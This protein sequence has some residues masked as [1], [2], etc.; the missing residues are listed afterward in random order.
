MLDYNLNSLVGPRCTELKVETPDKYR[1]QPRTLLQ[2]L[3]TVYL[4]LCKSKEFIQAVARDGRSYKKELFTKAAEILTRHGL[5][6]DRDVK[7][8]KKFVSDVEEVI[9]RE[10]AGEEVLGEVPEEFLGKRNL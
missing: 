2:Q 7:V 1:F 9:E 8:L 5:K 3:I 4:N 6:L 10:A